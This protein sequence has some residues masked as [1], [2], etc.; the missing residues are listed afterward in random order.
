[1]KYNYEN[2]ITNAASYACNMNPS[3][4]KRTNNIYVYVQLLGSEALINDGIKVYF[5]VGQNLNISNNPISRS[6]INHL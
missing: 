5:T 1:M 4:D 6:G 2:S 3:R